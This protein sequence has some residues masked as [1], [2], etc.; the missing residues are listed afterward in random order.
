M[1]APARSGAM[2]S[3]EDGPLLRGAGRYLSDLPG[4]K[5]HAAFVRAD[6]AHGRIVRLDPSAAQAASGVVA[7]LTADDLGLAPLRGHPM[8]DARFTRPPLARDTV[9]FVGE[10]VAV[11]VADTAAHAVDAVELVVVEFEP[12]PVTSSVDDASAAVAWELATGGRAVRPR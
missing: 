4:E 12:L 11:V 5:L 9:R 10:P 2:R 3:V 8:L 7:V 1:A 6:V